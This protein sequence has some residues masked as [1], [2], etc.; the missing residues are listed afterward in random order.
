MEIPQQ[1]RSPEHSWHSSIWLLFYKV[2]TSNS[3]DIYTYLQDTCSY[4][5]KTIVAL[6]IY[7]W[8]SEEYALGNIGDILLNFKVGGLGSQDLVLRP[9]HNHEQVTWPLSE[10]LPIC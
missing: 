7:I 1:Q 2:I 10:S 8:D 9:N 4:I 3:I 5:Y 6:S